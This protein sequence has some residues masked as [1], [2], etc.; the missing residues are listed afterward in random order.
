MYECTQTNFVQKSIVV[1]ILES[2]CY[3]PCSIFKLSFCFISLLNTGVSDFVMQIN[4]D[5]GF[6]YVKLVSQKLYKQKRPPHKNYTRW[7][8]VQKNKGLIKP[9][10]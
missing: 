8:K 5:L 9:V 6:R 4:N 3:R 7:S 2:Q 1:C 10:Q